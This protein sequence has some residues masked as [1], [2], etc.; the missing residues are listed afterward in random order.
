MDD[1]IRKRL[2][3][4]GFEL[5]T[6]WV[7]LAIDGG[8]DLMEIVVAADGIIEAAERYAAMKIVLGDDFEKVM[9]SKMRVEVEKAIKEAEEAI[10]GD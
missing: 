9:E 7:N 6:K 1:E 5:A 2:N 10:N 3:E 8:Y 4:R